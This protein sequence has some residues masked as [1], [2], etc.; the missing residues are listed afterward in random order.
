M[1]SADYPVGKALSVGSYL[2]STESHILFRTDHIHKPIPYFSSV[3][4]KLC[5]GGP[6][7]TGRSRCI[8]NKTLL[9][10]VELLAPYDVVMLY[11]L[12]I[13]ALVPLF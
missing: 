10:I 11:S 1:K 9:G 2:H 13:I 3:I 6:F 12:Y 7:I 4:H 8:L 5:I